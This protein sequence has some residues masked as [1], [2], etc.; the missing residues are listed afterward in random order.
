MADLN[1]SNMT[2]N[3]TENTYM[4][5]II[6]YQVMRPNKTDCMHYAWS[7]QMFPTLFISHT[8][9]QCAPKNHCNISYNLEEF[10]QS[11]SYGSVDIPGKD[12]DFAMAI[13]FHR[14]IE[15]NVTKKHEASDVFHPCQASNASDP[16]YKSTYLNQS[17]LEWSSNIDGESLMAKSLENNS[18]LQFTIRVSAC[19]YCG[20]HLTII[21]VIFTSCSTTFHPPPMTHACPTS[22]VPSSLR[23]QP[24]LIWKYRTFPTSYQLPRNLPLGLLWSCS[25]STD[26]IPSTGVSQ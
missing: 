9:D 2:S 23:T 19:V 4:P 26:Q 11:Q 7:A 12:G 21:C 22:L 5:D 3:H 20:V 25:W 10:S 14:L 8:E 15:F 13:I 1:M 16:E 17:E 6:Y 24:H 18:T